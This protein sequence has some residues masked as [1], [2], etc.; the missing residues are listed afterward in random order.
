MASIVQVDGEYCTGWWRVLYFVN[1]IKISIS[2]PTYVLII[3]YPFLRLQQNYCHLTLIIISAS[4]IHFHIVKWFQLLLCNINN[5]GLEA[6]QHFLSYIQVLIRCAGLP[7]CIEAVVVYYSSSHLNSIHPEFHPYCSARTDYFLAHVAAE[8]NTDAWY[9]TFCPP[10]SIMVLMTFLLGAIF[11]CD[12]YTSPCRFNIQQSLKEGSSALVLHCTL[13][14]SLASV[15]LWTSSKW[16]SRELRQ[17]P[18]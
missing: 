15:L 17:F 3:Q 4:F 5:S 6:H 9:R 18:C 2:F 8:S 12:V 11:I 14:W 10:A 7:L 16:I 1:A 13:I